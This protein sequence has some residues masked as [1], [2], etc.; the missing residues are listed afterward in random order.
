MSAKLTND[1][2]LLHIYSDVQV[3][4]NE[5]RLHR[6]LIFTI[7]SLVVLIVFRLLTL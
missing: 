1:K 7:L 6:K 5:M 4:K 3:L 2:L